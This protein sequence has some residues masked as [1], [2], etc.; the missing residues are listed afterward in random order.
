MKY[1]IKYFLLQGA[2][3]KKKN[4]SL[5]DGKVIDHIATDIDFLNLLA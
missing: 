4:V 3:V 5:V 1:I 2:G